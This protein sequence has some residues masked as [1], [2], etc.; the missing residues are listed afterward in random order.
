MIAIIIDKLNTV[1]VAEMVNVV[2]A[3]IIVFLIK[4]ERIP[5]AILIE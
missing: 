5:N 3:G 4:V 1:I 2:V